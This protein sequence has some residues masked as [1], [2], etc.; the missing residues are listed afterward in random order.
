MMGAM[1]FYHQPLCSEGSGTWL[2]I[3]EDGIIDEGALELAL[4]LD[5][6]ES[7]VLVTG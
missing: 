3:A 5:V 2:A 7:T 1:P 6:A 4:T